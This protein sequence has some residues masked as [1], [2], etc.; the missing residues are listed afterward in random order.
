M[1]RL[2]KIIVDNGIAGQVYNTTSG[3]QFI[4]DFCDNFSYSDPVDGSQTTNQG[5]R[6]IFKDGTR[7]V[8]RLSGTGSSGATLRMYIDTYEADPKR[9]ELSS[10]VSLSVAF[11]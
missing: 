1:N 10:Q 7:F 2:K 9:H 11:F 5:F 4:G 3:Q 6:L 8:Y